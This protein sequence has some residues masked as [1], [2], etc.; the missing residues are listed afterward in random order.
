ME[1]TGMGNLLQDIRYGLRVL[2]K[3][4]GF[5]AVAVLTLALGIGATTSI[6]SVV[7]GIILRPLPYHDSE[8]LISMY[9]AEERDD[10]DN[11]SGATFV[12]VVAA[13]ESFE[14]IAAIDEKNLILAEGDVPLVIKGVTVTPNWFIMLGVEAHAGRSLSP[15]IDTPGAERTAVINYGLWQSQF[16]GDESVVG[17]TL[18]LSDE[19]YTIVG[20][21]PVDFNYPSTAQIWI[22]PRYR[23]P[24]PPFEFGIDPAENRGAQY[25][26]VV[27]RLKEGVT[28]QQARAEM[29][30]IAVRMEEDFPDT[31]AGERFNLIPLHE[32]LVGD[33]R[34][35]LLVLFAAVGFVLLI[36]CSNVANLLLVRASGRER[37]IAIR[38]AMGAKRQRIVR[39]LIN[40]SVLL[41]LL[42]GLLGLLLALWGTDALLAIAPEDIPRAAEVAVDLRVLIFTVLISILTGLLFGLA[43]ALQ[44]SNQ[45][46]QQTIRESGI[47]HAA[48]RRGGRIRSSLI[49]GEVAVSLLLLVGAGLMVR[50]FLKLGAVD[51]GFDS[52][53]LLTARVWIP[54]TRYDDIS[55]VRG[56]YRDVIEQVRALPGVESSGAV[57]SLP[58]HSGITG[59][60]GFSIE[61]RTSEPGR[62]PV[63][64]YQISTFDYFPTMGIP[65]LRGELFSENDD[66]NT[67]SVAVIN[68]AL[69][70]RY[71]QGED[72]IGKRITW[73]DPENEETDWTTII[74]IVANTRFEG[75]DTDPRPEV[76][77]PYLQDPFP[78]M[79]LVVRS[80]L[81]V[82]A[83]VTGLRRAVAEIDP[84]QPVTEIMS[85]ERILSVSL[86]EQ[87]FNMLLLGM[88]ALAA[89]I[90]AA[91]GLYGVLSFSVTQ[92]YREIGILM[93][94]G[95]PSNRMIGQIL[96]EGF[97]MVLIGLLIGILGALAMTGLIA[98]L[99][100]GVRP[101]DPV[102]FLI[103]ILLLSVV[104]LAASY[105][106]ARKAS[107]MDPVTAIR[108]E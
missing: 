78:F 108:T 41:A 55:K 79:T 77:R 74:G 27:G 54:E 12:D 2:V 10:R 44:C 81:E 97:G 17:R 100:Y 23:V 83:V 29:D 92:R 8:R 104:A 45:R 94:L 36:A 13:C 96:R 49:V 75:L 1:K 48:G 28:L 40:E 60:L 76:F 64:G 56:F 26:D 57:L 82:G 14:H 52:R 4:P 80:G 30:A 7:N 35:L 84:V 63:A 101:I 39:Q 91:V 16:G 61:G 99:V 31:K 3:N 93:A 47:R 102:S 37:E 32:S 87:R 59:T 88:F 72:P 50:T 20:V 89:L 34:P 66:E 103:G 6:F 9:V 18:T 98:N 11:W 62:V 105:I 70:E 85:M 67:P 65:L 15:D 22:A 24:D 5:T 95:A 58:I 107:R 71:W 25:F 53:N 86:G 21:M 43:P 90:M 73:G 42:G 69:L 51:P 68:Q 38:M 46:I 33:V 106:P 19:L